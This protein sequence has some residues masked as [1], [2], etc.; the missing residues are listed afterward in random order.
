M[1]CHAGWQLKQ[2]RPI[3]LKLA[4]HLSLGKTLK[5]CS[6]LTGLSYWQVSRL[7]GTPLIQVMIAQARQSRLEAEALVQQGPNTLLRVEEYK[8]LKDLAQIRDFSANTEHRLSACSKSQRLLE[9]LRQRQEEH[10]QERDE[11]RVIL[12]EG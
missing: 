5:E 4:E 3:H 11:I 1:P 6:R 12:E 10:A 9:H 8:L 7:R 2:S